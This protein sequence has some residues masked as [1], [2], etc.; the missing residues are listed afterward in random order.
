MPKVRQSSRFGENRPS[1]SCGCALHE[2]AKLF[3]PVHRLNA[4][5]APP[6]R[7]IFP[8]RRLNGISVVRRVYFFSTFFFATCAKGVSHR[9]PWGEY[10]PTPGTISIWLWRRHAVLT[11]ASRSTHSFI[12]IVILCPLPH[13]RI[14]FL[15]MRQPGRFRPQM[16]QN[17]T[18]VWAGHSSTGHRVSP[19]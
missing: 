5:F 2:P 7:L 10:G 8:S 15:P 11:S 3:S 19:S 9:P 13:S 18:S 16:G 6:G 12:D 14:A 4:G 17:R 1:L